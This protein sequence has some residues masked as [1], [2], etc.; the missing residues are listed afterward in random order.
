MRKSH[1]FTLIELLVVVTVIVALLAMLTPALDK[2]IEQAE[3][4]VCA[5]SLHS[6]G[7]AL[8]QYYF[9][10]KRSLLSSMKVNLPGAQPNAMYPNLVWARIADAATDWAD[11]ATKAGAWNAQRM[12]PYVGGADEVA[13]QWKGPWYCP[14]NKASLKDQ[15]NF[16]SANISGWFVSDYA[17]FAR[18]EMWRASATRPEELT[19]NSLAGDRLLMADALY[20]ETGNLAWWFNHG[21]DGWSTHDTAWGGPKQVKPN[22]SGT[23]Q[24]FGD[25][26]VRWISAT[27]QDLAE[28]LKIPPEA[29]GH[30]VSNHTDNT[31]PLTDGN[32]NF[33]LK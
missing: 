12:K 11:P 31:K 22:I 2:A 1:A 28:G 7:A 17:Y 3:R 23:N 30:W 18:S 24:L 26:S 29:D 20:Y 9:D 4:A 5:G 15:N 14:S 25:G 16:N 6:W 32:L 19:A 13:L 21:P 10:N 8:S 27:A 33:Y